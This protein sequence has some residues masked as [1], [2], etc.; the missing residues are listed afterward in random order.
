MT[1]KNTLEEISFILDKCSRS[2]NYDGLPYFFG[3]AVE[4]KVIAAEKCPGVL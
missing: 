4:Q 1:E 3:L 2:F